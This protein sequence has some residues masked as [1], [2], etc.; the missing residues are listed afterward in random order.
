MPQFVIQLSCI[1]MQRHQCYSVMN[2]LPIGQHS[3]A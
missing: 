3:H 1:V 2:L